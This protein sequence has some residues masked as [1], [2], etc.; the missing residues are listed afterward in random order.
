[1]SLAEG[2][3]PFTRDSPLLDPWRPLYVRTLPDRMI[4]GVEVRPPHTN[5]RGTVHGGLFAA[6]ADQAMGISCAAGLRSAGL[7]VANLWTSSMTLDYL[8][9]ARP[10]QWLAFETYFTRAGKT[11][12]HAECDITADGVTVARAR[13]S[14]RVALDRAAPAAA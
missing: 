6:L 8:G 13:A 10:G 14:F 1:M 4:L 5:S 2:F 9:V 3:E 12:C 11:L 7:A